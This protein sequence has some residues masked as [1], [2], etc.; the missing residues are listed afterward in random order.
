MGSEACLSALLAMPSYAWRKGL[1]T[2]RIGGKRGSTCVKARGAREQA[3]TYL[4]CSVLPS[5]APATMLCP[6]PLS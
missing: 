5:G 1:H 6:Q 3:L 2:P 4:T